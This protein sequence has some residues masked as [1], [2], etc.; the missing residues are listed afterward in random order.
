MEHVKR[1]LSQLERQ[2]PGKKFKYASDQS[3]RDN[4]WSNAR[5]HD[6]ERDRDV[7]KSITSTSGLHKGN[8]NS[9]KSTQGQHSNLVC[10]KCS[11]SHRI[12]ECPKF[13]KMSTE[14][15]QTWA[16]GEGI[17][18]NCLTKHHRTDECTKNGCTQCD[19]DKHH[20]VFC[21]KQMVF[22]TN[23]VLLPKRSRRGR[24]TDQE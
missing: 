4:A 16:E 23:L 24:R 22:Q 12:L 15:R 18:C 7:G 9:S 2:R 3:H 14:D 5:T 10:W 17:C 6:K 8:G 19:G 21:P 11:K 13:E 20:K 1:P